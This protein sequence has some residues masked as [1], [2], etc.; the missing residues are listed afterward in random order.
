MAKPR[1]LRLSKTAQS[2]IEKID[3]YSFE[4][5]G[6]KTASAYMAGLEARLKALLVTPMLGVDRADLRPGYRA[7]LSGSHI[8]YYRIEDAFIYILTI[9]HHSQDHEAFLVEVIEDR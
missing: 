8:I 7:L 5:W 2:D 3:Y 6:E 4:K 9:L 1:K